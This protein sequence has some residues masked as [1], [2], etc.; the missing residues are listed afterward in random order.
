METR[1]ELSHRDV[2]EKSLKLS[3]SLRKMGL[4]V[5][6]RIAI[7]SENNLNF[8]IG[9]LSSIFN[10]S[11]ICPLNPLYTEREFIH[12]LT[13]SKPKYIFVSGFVLSKMRK[14]V[15][16][17]TWRP[18]LIL[19]NEI[20]NS[21]VVSISELISKISYETLKNY[22]LPKIDKNEHVSIIACSSG[23]TGLPKGVM[24]TDKNVLNQLRHFAESRALKLTDNISVLGL[25]PLFHAYGLFVSFLVFASGAK[26]IVLPRFDERLFLEAIS[27]YKIDSLALVPPL[28]VFLA[29][30][31]IVDEYDLSCVKEIA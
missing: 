5:N 6:D 15:D 25:L 11:T 24:L 31:P 26:L 27:K 30:S 8:G 23:T 4:E 29:K 7:C 14:I 28:M 9:V 1:E 20:P 16:D 17:L 22:R 10:G 18:Q 21:K 13:I 2:L 12:S 3:L 19:L